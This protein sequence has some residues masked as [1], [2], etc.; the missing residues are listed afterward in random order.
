M[1][2]A[3]KR[4]TDKV[5]LISLP[6]TGKNH[7]IMFHFPQNFHFFAEHVHFFFQFG[8][9]VY[10]PPLSPQPGQLENPFTVYSWLGFEED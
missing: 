5:L 2:W 9:N 6:Y 8:K 3:L 1:S 4:L 10:I 7:V